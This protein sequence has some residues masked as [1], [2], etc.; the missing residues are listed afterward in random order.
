MSAFTL[1]M[2]AAASMLLD[3]MG[4]ILFPNLAVLRIAGRLAFPLFAY[5]V[6]EGFQYT[7][8]RKRYFLQIFLLGLVCQAAYAASGGELHYLGVLLTFSFSILLMWAADMAG[9]LW[10]SK[11]GRGRA[12]LTAAGVIAGLIL[13]LHAVEV[14]YGLFGI[15]LPVFAYAGRN[16]R[17]KLLLF[18]LGLVALCI[19]LTKHGGFDIQWWSLFSLPVLCLYNGR[20]GKYR[21]KSFFYVFYPA[22]LLLLYLL[23]MLR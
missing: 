22:H 3:H 7:R 16:R 9:A 13:L 15:L 2:I 11:T 6:G 19:D 4:L 23:A 1:K 10:R 21:W 14:D 17:E 5:C 20:P 12:W 8:S 18:S